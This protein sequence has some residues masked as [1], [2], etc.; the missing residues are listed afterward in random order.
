MLFRS[1]EIRFFVDDDNLV[2]NVADILIDQN[3]LRHSH[4]LLKIAIKDRNKFRTP[5]FK[6]NE[7]HRKSLKKSWQKKDTL[8]GIEEDEL[9][10]YLNFIRSRM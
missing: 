10:S 4:F 2:R 9:E 1:S 3:L 6:N 7:H 8:E 5:P